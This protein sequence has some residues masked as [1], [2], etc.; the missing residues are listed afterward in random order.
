MK[1]KDTISESD[2]WSQAA[3]IYLD[4]DTHNLE[5]LIKSSK[6][7]QLLIKNKFKLTKKVK[8]EIYKNRF[9]QMF[10]IHVSANLAHRNLATDFIL[11]EIWSPFFE[12]ELKYNKKT[13]AFDFIDSYVLDE[14]GHFNTQVAVIIERLTMRKAVDLIKPLYDSHYDRWIFKKYTKKIKEYIYTY[15]PIQDIVNQIRYSKDN[16]GKK[17]PYRT[18]EILDIVYPDWEKNRN[19]FI[20]K[21]NLGIR[22][23][24][25]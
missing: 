2:L 16:T 9:D 18:A 23:K 1:K 3:E 10:L 14:K 15:R 8:D 7:T 5:P 19:F 12:N 24:L 6:F 4:I 25:Y 22:R 20:K 21:K 13:S 11:D 17:T